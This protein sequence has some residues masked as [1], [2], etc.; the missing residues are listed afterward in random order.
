MVFS[1]FNAWL[2]GLLFDIE[3]HCV[4]MY[5]IFDIQQISAL[6]LHAYIRNYPLDVMNINPNFTIH[7]KEFQ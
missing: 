2:N 6:S 4:A 7:Q 5:L 1:F 3:V